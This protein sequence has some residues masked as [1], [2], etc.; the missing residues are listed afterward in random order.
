MLEINERHASELCSGVTFL[1]LGL[2]GLYF[3][4]QEGNTAARFG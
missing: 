4:L 1:L 3:I 2:Q